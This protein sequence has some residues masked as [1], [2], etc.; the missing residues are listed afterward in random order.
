MIKEVRVDEPQQRTRSGSFG[1]NI[2][3]FFSS[4]KSS[5]ST[6]PTRR[7]GSLN[8][9]VPVVQAD[10]IRESSVPAAAATTKDTLSPFGLQPVSSTGAQP[11][12]VGYHQRPRQSTPVPPMRDPSSMQYTVRWGSW[13]CC[14]WYDTCMRWS[15]PSSLCCLCYPPA[16]VVCLLAAGVW[17]LSVLICMSAHHA[18]TAPYLFVLHRLRLN[19]FSVW[20]RT[21]R[22]CADAGISISRETW[23][24]G[25]RFDAA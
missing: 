24:N 1:S 4:S 18:C 9:P 20:R 15:F 19:D 23:R 2:R 22:F 13:A 5:T 21:R 16:V 17:P 12:E 11:Q 8:R 3:R 7:G 14:N 10:I 25:T 6:T